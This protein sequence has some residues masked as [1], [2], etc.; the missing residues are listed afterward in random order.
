M[1]HPVRPQATALTATLQI[2]FLPQGEA[3]ELARAPPFTFKCG[4]TKQ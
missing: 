2:E 4:Y 3:M 1:H